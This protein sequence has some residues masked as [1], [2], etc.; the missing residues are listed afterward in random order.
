MATRATRPAAFLSL[1]LAALSAAGCDTLHP[2]HLVGRLNDQAGNPMPHHAVVLDY[3]PCADAEWFLT[4]AKC[5][6]YHYSEQSFT[7]TDADG[8]F[9]GKFA[10]VR[11]GHNVA[12][13]P[14]FTL[15]VPCATD[16]AFAIAFDKDGMKYR[17][18]N[19]RT[20]EWESEARGAKQGVVT[21]TLTRTEEPWKTGKYE[22][23]WLTARAEVTVTVKAAPRPAGGPEVTGP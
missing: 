17:T 8:S 20:D 22:H 23:T 1:V 21:G 5:P 6:T 18:F 13:P 9:D 10:L 11:P 2:V 14:C 15:I 16:T 4:Q 19:M 12:P 7:R 3:Y